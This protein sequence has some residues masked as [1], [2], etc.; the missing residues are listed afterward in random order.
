MPLAHYQPPLPTPASCGV[1]VE[2]TP[3]L[4]AYSAK[5]G[6]LLFLAAGSMCR[7]I[8]APVVAAHL[9]G[10]HGACL[11]SI[12][13]DGDHCIGLL[14]EKLA[15]VFGTVTRNVDPDLLHRLDCKRMNV[16]RRFGS[17]TRHIK[18]VTGSSP[19]DTFSEMG[20]ARVAGAEDEN[21]WFCHGLGELAA[22]SAGAAAI[23]IVRSSGNANVFGQ[24]VCLLLCELEQE[25]AVRGLCRD[26]RELGKIAVF[27]LHFDIEIILTEER[28]SLVQDRGKRSGEKA[29][30]GVICHPCLK[31][32]G[33][34]VPDRPAA[35]DESPVG[36][37]NLSD[38]SV[39]LDPAAICQDEAEFMFWM[40]LKVPL[41]FG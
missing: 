36:A 5:D 3:D 6:E 28:L 8:K 7:A 29:M 38:V 9:A 13:A 27:A 12:A 26:N 18:D 1:S 11:I 34:R 15:E 24:A 10:E 40:L 16:A 19:R 20:A 22:A 17:G 23:P 25:H 21:Q 30:I 4:I 37:T 2:N 31:G 14:I 33:R 41:E 39:C 35:V 32:A